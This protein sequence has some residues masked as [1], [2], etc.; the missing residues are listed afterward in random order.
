LK[1]KE[2]FEISKRRLQELSNQRSAIEAT[3]KKKMSSINQ[4]K[5]E[6][7]TVQNSLDELM[8]VR[9]PDITS[10]VCGNYFSLSFDSLIF[11]RCAPM[12]IYYSGKWILALVTT[13]FIQSNHFIF[14]IK[15]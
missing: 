11:S 3:I 6:L 2:K 9:E 5:S 14:V 12:D 10:L 13:C 4:M 1:V 7:R 8:K 15:N